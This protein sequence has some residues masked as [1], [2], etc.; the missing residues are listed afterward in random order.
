MT[1]TLTPEGRTLRGVY[2]IRGHAEGLS[3]NSPEWDDVADDLMCVPRYN[4]VKTHRDHPDFEVG[5]VLRAHWKKLAT[6]P[7]FDG[8][9]HPKQSR[10]WF[11]KFRY[12]LSLSGNDTGSNFLSAASS[13][14][15]I[16]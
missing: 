5:F 8:L 6:S 7:A 2:N 3:E 13:N 9:C 15:L 16:L 4:I 11:Q 1:D 14:A 10:T 12:I